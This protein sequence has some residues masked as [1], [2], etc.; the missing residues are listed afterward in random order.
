MKKTKLK[1]YLKDFALTVLG[2]VLY[3]MS[4]NMF[5]VPND[6]VQGGLTG[7]SIMLN[8]LF[9]VIP[10]GTAIFVMNIPLFIIGAFKIGKKFILRTFAATFIFTAAIDIGELFIKPYSGD[11]LLACLFC[12][13]FSGLGLAFVMFSGA[14]TGGTEIV[15]ILVRQKMPH[16]PIGRMI[17]FVDLLIISASYFVYRN[18]EVIMYAVV[19][20]FVSTKV[21]DFVLGGAGHNKVMFVVTD[22]P[23]KIAAAVMKKINRGVTVLPASGGYSEKEKS[24]LFCVARASE[25][26][27]VNRMLLDIDK[28]SFTVVGDIGEVLGNGWKSNK[29]NI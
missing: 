12:G 11:N 21:I 15:A 25:I 23:K 14:T 3:S 17:L 10:V 5:S 2:A 27:R 7:I 6:I 1:I 26:A 4:V 16:I 9:P 28:N 20:L 24:L 13:V 8:R 19:A 22:S 29:E 18:V